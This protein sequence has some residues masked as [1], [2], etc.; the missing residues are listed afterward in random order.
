M[1]ESHAASGLANPLDRGRRIRAVLFDLDGTLYR[2]APVRSLMA[3]ELALVPIRSPLGAS[4]RLRALRLYR[5]AQEDL[6]TARAGSSIAGE[7]LARATAGS[8]LSSAETEQLVD[9]WMFRR[10]LK[11]LRRWRTPGLLPLL[12]RLDA[13]GVPAGILSDYPAE[14]KLAALGLS[15][16]FSPVLCAGDPAI[17]ALKP[18]PRGFLRACATWHLPP[19]DVLMIGD[20]P[21]VDAAGAHAAGMPCVIVGRRARRRSRSAR[22]LTVPSF[23]SLCRVFDDCR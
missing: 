9:E 18:S 15:D 6:R 3:I 5:R 13:A 22:Y 4:R 7:Q 1:R 8:G 23:G 20:R 16:R 21:D 19:R 10:P 17:G 14:R 2:Q 11:Y 12:A